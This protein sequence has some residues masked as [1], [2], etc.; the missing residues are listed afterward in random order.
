[1]F[2]LVLLQDRKLEAWEIVQKLHNSPD[3]PDQL[4][5]RE[6]YY[7]MMSQAEFDRRL[8]QEESVLDLFRKPSYR[9][10]LICGGLTMFA[11]ESSGIL[12]IYSK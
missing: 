11:C 10:R 8:V 6:E 3:D 7:Q 1:M 12:V 4:F 9:K 5:A 2:T